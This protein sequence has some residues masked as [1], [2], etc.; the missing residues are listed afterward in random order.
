MKTYFKIIVIIC[1]FICQHAYSQSINVVGYLNSQEIPT[2]VI[3]SI[4]T[5]PDGNLLFCFHDGNKKCILYS[6]INKITTGYYINLGLP[7]GVLWA[8]CNIN[9]DNQEDKGSLCTYNEISEI[10][11]IKDG[12]LPTREEINE[13]I[14]CC[15]W[16]WSTNNGIN[17]YYVEGPNKNKIFLP[18]TGVNPNDGRGYL[19]EGTQGY[20]WTSDVTTFNPSMNYTLRFSSERIFEGG[21]YR[22]YFRSEIGKIN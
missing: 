22:E 16:R 8:Q 1:M 11:Q 19:Y 21:D 3:D 5:Q 4:V 12:R 6:E 13:L 7:S 17:G 14:N 9:S 2:N 15:S 10:M 18:T 20:Y